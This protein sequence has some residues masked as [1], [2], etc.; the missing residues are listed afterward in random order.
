MKPL[1]TVHAGEY[2]VG[3]YIEEHYKQARVW[4]PSRDTGVDLLISDKKGRSTVSVQVKFGKDYL[5]T[6]GEP[7]F[8]QKLR[9]SC[10]FAINRAK[11]KKSEADFWVFVLNG[12]KSQTPD[13]VVIPVGKLRERLRQIHGTK[14]K[15]IQTY[16]TVTEKNRCWETRDLTGGKADEHLIAD[17]VYKKN[18]ARDFTRWLNAWERLMKRVGR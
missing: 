18:R 9:V 7:K 8:R 13:Y 14:S 5:P 10:W 17:G 4:I 1:F 16:L 3:S 11:L 6:V 12:F 15:T 2:L